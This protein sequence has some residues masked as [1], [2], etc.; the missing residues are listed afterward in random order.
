ME[1]GTLRDFSEKIARYFL[2]FL[3]TDFKKQ[4]LPRR[5]LQAEK[6]AQIR[7]EQF[8]AL[9]TAFRS[10]LTD[11]VKNWKPVMITPGKFTRPLNPTLIDYLQRRI[12]AIADGEFEGIALELNSY[13]IEAYGRIA[14]DHEAWV[15]DVLQR[16]GTLADDRIVRPLVETVRATLVR[17]A[18]DP[19]DRAF[20]LE[21]S[22]ISKL[23]EGLSQTLPSALN[24][25]AATQN[26][27]QIG[28]VL[29]AELDADGCRGILREAAQE[30]WTADAL[31]QLRD[32][33][34]Y[35]D[36]GENLQAYLYVGTLKYRNQ[37]Y[38]LFYL[39]ITI[40][41]E[42][43]GIGLTLEPHLYVNRQALEYVLQDLSDSNS[44]ISPIRDRIVYLGPQQK[45]AQVLDAMAGTASA[46]LGLPRAIKLS[47]S[48]VEHEST[49]K[50]AVRNQILIA[51]FDRADE[52]LVNDYE[53]I[54]ASAQSGGDNLI[55]LFED[56]L[57]AVMGGEPTS[58]IASVERDWIESP[59]AARLIAESPIPVNEEQRK[60]LMALG[61]AD[62]RFVVVEGPPGTGKS[63]T[64]SAIAFDAIRTGK[65]VLILS[66]KTEALD[67]VED[68]LEKTIAAVRPS[69]DFPNPLL[70][71]GKTGN[72][73][74]RLVSL[75][76]SQQIMRE[77][78]AANANKTEVIKSTEVQ[79]TA[80]SADL[81]SA[82]ETVSASALADVV[83]AFALEQ[84]LDARDA[85]VCESLRAMA[86]ETQGGAFLSFAEAMKTSTLDEDSLDATIMAIRQSPKT[87]PSV[88]GI[89]A[90]ARRR[91]VATSFAQ[92]APIIA[93][94]RFDPMSEEQARF[95]LSVVQQYEALRQPLFG[96]LFRGGQVR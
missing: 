42:G 57:K 20:E 32:L 59:L 67:V 60:I 74:S 75:N 83:R 49:L 11:E 46:A 55:T 54:L 72:N 27:T 48:S 64:I 14:D 41:R 4:S 37:T 29:S 44:V 62:C 53:Q 5:R 80:L 45:A 91:A 96:Y 13:A 94:R 2:D 9:R 85:D 35:I 61:R 38:P 69:E 86:E 82:S 79:R 12:E 56:I 71:L 70:R 90:E 51:A 18:D 36:T 17:N 95:V 23:T 3:Q 30:F 87:P 34:A 1:G 78:A 26:V 65:S 39:P 28:E 93:M 7:L 33:L 52:A 25:Y 22:L 50:V 40:S 68:K 66:D 89:L 92:S 6:G 47:S 88:A 84:S 81:H 77:H 10:L 43:A 21:A 63:H 58:L 8:P 76:S 73:Y 19:D 24:D 16:A 31:S 15:D